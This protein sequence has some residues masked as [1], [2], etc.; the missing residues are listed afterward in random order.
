M[1]YLKACTRCRGDL[2]TEWDLRDRYVTC[3]Q[4]GHVLSPREELVLQLHAEKWAMAREAQ[5]PN[6]V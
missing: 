2:F 4:C 5:H 3:L 1:V 6:S